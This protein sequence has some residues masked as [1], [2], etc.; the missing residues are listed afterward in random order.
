[1]K[2]FSLLDE[3]EKKKRTW[4]KRIFILVGIVFIIVLANIPF[5][6]SRF[7]GNPFNP[8]NHPILSR[9]RQNVYREGV[10]SGVQYYIYTFETQEE[11]R[12]YVVFF[13]NTTE[14]DLFV[15]L[16]DETISLPAL[17]SSFVA[18]SRN[19]SANGGYLNEKEFEFTFGE[20]DFA[21]SNLSNALTDGCF[22]FEYD[23]NKSLLFLNRAGYIVRAVT[24]SDSLFCPDFDYSF[25][26][27][28]KN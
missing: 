8:E 16:D 13:W 21:E 22:S 6:A 15:H 14:Q 25:V 4:V 28:V 12:N 2:N 23:G 7:R 9:I 26:W 11:K 1:M 10:I 24:T 18:V 3:K 5:I 27:S 20:C 17:Q 19:Y